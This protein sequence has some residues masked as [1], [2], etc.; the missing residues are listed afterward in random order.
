MTEPSAQTDADL[1]QA[2]ERARIAK[3]TRSGINPA[4]L[5]LAGLLLA[6]SGFLGGYLIGGNTAGAQEGPIS[7]GMVVRGEGP[8]GGP[9]GQPA[10]LTIGTIESISGDTFK[11]KTESGDSVKVQV[12]DDTS[13]RIN[14]EGTIQ[15][16][17]KGDNVVVNGQRDGDTIEAENVGSGMM[18]R[19]EGGAKGAGG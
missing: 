8:G 12:V 18:M 14:K 7:G 2:L 6:G 11:V 19:R 10:N 16:L 3:P 5:A 15:D 9:G 17:A 1:E 4:T 13:I